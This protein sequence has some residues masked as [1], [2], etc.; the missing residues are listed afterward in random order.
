MR[1][2]DQALPAGVPGRF[3]RLLH[4]GNVVVDV[5]L[6]VPALP[7]RGGD[8]LASQAECMAGG[9]FNVMAAAARQGLRAAYAG[10][11]GT[12]PFGTLARAALAREGI[13]VIQPVR[14]GLDTG[15]VVT[16]VDAG[17]E[18]TF[19]TS[20][21]A[22]ATLTAADLDPVQPAPRDAVYLSGYSLVQAG[23]R[24][25]LLGWLARLGAGHTMFFDPGPLVGSIPA[26]ALAAVL[27]RAD[28]LTC[29]AREA[30]ILAGSTDPWAAVTALTSRTSRSR[31]V[32]RTGPDGC[33]VGRPDAPVVHV[34]GFSVR[35]ADT[36][37]AGDAHS[38]AFIAALAAG[39]AEPAAARSANA[40]AALSVTRR[41]P[42]TA[43][44][45]EELARFLAT[46]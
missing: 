15:F 36:N 8:V 35:V 29:N 3:D 28:W 10:A 32:V 7:E 4:L 25:T 45:R 24:A 26:R 21:G 22:E 31:V 16:I 20:R 23:S 34:P 19:L 11:H 12:G 33:L 13:D 1:R 41:G 46:T 27:D 5:V 42:A 37:G 40:A 17:G 39:A 44:T 30:A 18:R 14:T 2:G 6:S 38:G 43:P 9:G